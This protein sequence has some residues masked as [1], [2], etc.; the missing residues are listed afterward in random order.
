[1]HNTRILTN[2]DKFKLQEKVTTGFLF[3]KKDE[4]R[5]LGKYDSMGDLRVVFY[6]TEEDTKLALKKY[7]NKDKWVEIA[8]FEN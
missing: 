7:L 1:M 3:W 8:K 6:D 2:G 5:D 4:W